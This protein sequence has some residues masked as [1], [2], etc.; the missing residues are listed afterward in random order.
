MAQFLFEDDDSKPVPDTS[1]MPLAGRMRPRSL[2][3]FVGQDDLVGPGRVLRNMIE[4]DSVTSMIFWGPPGVGKTTLAEIIASSTDARFV[5]YS[6]VTGGIKEVKDIMAAAETR[7]RMGQR[8]VLFVDEIHRFNKAQQDAFLPYVEKGSIVLIGATTENPSF[9]INSALLSRC[10]VFVLH[11]IPKDALVGMLRRSLTDPRGFPN[12]KVR[13]SD[14]VLEAIALYSD[15]DARTAYNVLES[16][17]AD[18]V[19]VDG[20]VIVGKR[21]VA[22]AAGRKNPI[23]DRD[24]DGH[25]DTI[26]ALHKSMRNS[27]PDAA[28]YWLA[29]MLVG[30]EDPLYI[31]RRLI[32]FAGDDV[33]LADPEAQIMASSCFQCCHDMGMPDCRYALAETVVYLSLAPRSNSIATAIDTAMQDAEKM[34]AEPVPLHLRNAPTE[35]MKDIG[36]SKGYQYAEDSEEGITR[37][38]CLPNSL[39]GREYYV[40]GNFGREKEYGDLLGRIRRWRAGNGDPPF[41]SLKRSQDKADGN[42]CDEY[43]RNAEPS[44]VSLPPK[45]V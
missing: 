33:G 39:K 35:L 22:E 8:T 34:F 32:E 42:D 1:G 2:D 6:A 27:D 5:R 36:Y 23:Y 15:G 17:V 31:A 37:M 40:P 28:V 11:P 16:A 19:A 45:T 10:R 41:R 30:G 12:L 7:R 38:Q 9:E 25:Y 13:A 14:D 26:S 4:R 21:T 29:R 20:T 18:S 3:E 43:H 24:G 44:A